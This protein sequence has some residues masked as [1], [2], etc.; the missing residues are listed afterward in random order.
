[1]TP[2]LEGNCR[3]QGPLDESDSEFE[4]NMVCNAGEQSLEVNLPEHTECSISTNA[5]KRC[6]NKEQDGKIEV[7]N[8]GDAL[9]SEKEAT[10][11]E[12]LSELTTSK[13]ATKDFV[14]REEM[15]GSK[16]TRMSSNIRR[17]KGN[18]SRKAGIASRLSDYGQKG[19]IQAISTIEQI[20]K[21][22]EAPDAFQ[23]N[24]KEKILSLGKQSEETCDKSRKAGIVSSHSDNKQKAEIQAT[25]V[26][27][28]SEN[29][30]E[31]PDASQSNE[32]E[33]ILSLGK[34]PEET[35]DK[36]R[37]EGITSSHSDYGQNA[38]IEATGMIE[39]SEKSLE[40]LGASQSY[41]GNIVHLGK[42]SEETC[43]KSRKVG[44]RRSRSDY[45]RKAKTLAT[46]MIEQSEKSL[47]T[48]GVS[49]STDEV[50]IFS[51]GK[52]LEETCD[53]STK[54]GIS[55]S[56]SD[57]GQKAEIQATSTTERSEKSLETPCASQLNDI[58]KILSLGKQ[59]GEI[60]NTSRK[61]SIASNH[62]DYGQKVEIQET[63]SV[64]QSEKSL[65]IPGASHLKDEEKIL[66]HG[67][68]SEES[69]DKCFDKE[70]TDVLQSNEM[71]AIEDIEVHEDERYIRKQEED[72]KELPLT[73]PN[74]ASNINSR[75]SDSVGTTSSKNDL[76]KC[77]MAPIIIL[78][79]INES[80]DSPGMQLTMP[81]CSDSDIHVPGTENSAGM[82][83][84]HVNGVVCNNKHLPEGQV[85]STFSRLE[86]TDE[87]AATQAESLL[88]V[89]VLLKG[90]SES[91]DMINAETTSTLALPRTMNSE[92]AIS[93]LTENSVDVTQKFEIEC[94]AGEFLPQ[95]NNIQIRTPASSN[96]ETI[97]IYADNSFPEHS[98][99]ANAIE[100]VNLSV[101]CGPLD[102]FS[103]SSPEKKE[104]SN[105]FISDGNISQ[106][107][108]SSFPLSV[109]PGNSSITSASQSVTIAKEIEAHS[110]CQQE[111]DVAFT[112]VCTES[113][114]TKNTI[115][116]VEEAKDT[117][118]VA[119]RSPEH[120]QSITTMEE[121]E[122]HSICQQEEDFS[123][124]SVCVESST[125]KN[126]IVVVE[127]AKDKLPVA[128]RSPEHLQNDCLK[129]NELNQ[130]FKFGEASKR[131]GLSELSSSSGVSVPC[132]ETV[133]SPGPLS[134]EDDV[135]TCD[136]CGNTGYEGML[137]VCSLCND[138]AEHTYCM[139]TMLDEVPCGD[140]L[141]EGCKL[142]QN[143]NVKMVETPPS[144]TIISKPTCLNTRKQ[145]SYGT[146]RS[147]LSAKLDK[148]K[149]VPERKRALKGI[150]SSLLSTKRQ[151]DTFE[152]GPATKKLSL[153]TSTSNLGS[154]S[155]NPKPTFSRE[156]S[157]KAPDIGKV[158]TSIAVSSTVNLPN[159]SVNDSGKSSTVY[160]VSSPRL[161]ANV[162]MSKNRLSSVSGR[163]NDFSI[164]TGTSKAGRNA[165]THTVKMSIDPSPP[166]RLNSFHKLSSGPKVV[167][168]SNHTS[169]LAKADRE[170]TSSSQQVGGI[171]KPLKCN[172]NTDSSTVLESRTASDVHNFETKEI[173][174]V[175]VTKDGPGFLRKKV[176]S[177]SSSIG[178]VSKPAGAVNL[179]KL[180]M[181]DRH[182]KP[183]TFPMKDSPKS[184]LVSSEAKRPVTPTQ[185]AANS[186]KDH[187]SLTFAEAGSSSLRVSNLIA[188]AARSLRDMP[189]TVS[190]KLS[191]LEETA[192]L[193]SF[194]N[195]GNDQNSEQRLQQSNS[196][197]DQAQQPGSGSPRQVSS[198]KEASYANQKSN[199]IESF[200]GTT[201]PSQEFDIKTRESCQVSTS[202]RDFGRTS[203]LRESSLINPTCTSS[204][205]AGE[206]IS[207]TGF[208][209]KK[210][211]GVD[212][213]D[214]QKDSCQKGL[215]DDEA[216]FHPGDSSH[217]TTAITHLTG[218]PAEDTVV[219]I[220]GNSSCSVPAPLDGTGPPGTEF[221]V[222]PCRGFS[223]VE[224]TKAT[225]LPEHN[226]LWQGG[227][228]VQSNKNCTHYF[229]GIQAH[230]STSAALKVLDTA[231]KFSSK[232]RL[233][234]VPRNSSWPLQF[235]HC[236]PSDKNIA[237]YFFAKD[238]ESYERPYRKLLD[239]MLKNDLAL[240][241]NF[242]GVELLVF[243]SNQLA[244]KSQRW[245]RLLFL[246]G[247]FREKKS[248]CVESSTC[249]S[250]NI[251]GESAKGDT[252]GSS[253]LNIND[254]TVV[255]HSSSVLGFSAFEEMDT[256][257][258]GDRESNPSE[259]TLRLTGDQ[260]LPSVSSQGEGQNGNYS[261]PNVPNSLLVEDKKVY[262]S[263][264]IDKKAAE[265][266]SV[267]KH[268]VGS[269]FESNEH[270]SSKSLQSNRLNCPDL[271][272]GFET[273]TTHKLYNG[274]DANFFE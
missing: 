139:E 187:N 2:I 236:H 127:E 186:S 245:N 120:R 228:Y 106:E 70:P 214:S 123:F 118:P 63:S 234:E 126:T 195:R 60:Y 260:I 71:P 166:L 238:H 16:K 178:T 101:D 110:I 76:D 251:Q 142:K 47:E 108:V 8:S 243:P 241:G 24:D 14:K 264:K 253:N 91:P 112:S 122:A 72:D 262:R 31:T 162:Q 205:A 84:I 153:G 257:G 28:E 266:S 134:G 136:I 61:A 179:E 165:P 45:G 96:V 167:K 92:K 121:I 98:L 105:R 67:K 54:A 10:G 271:S 183:V 75:N 160:G 131:V 225:S 208:Y 23:S 57:Y 53:K 274:R 220:K 197:Q 81:F 210:K 78:D 259:G 15:P 270:P 117:L 211:S 133:K 51:V 230:A 95:N 272:V 235:H 191:T 217:I 206:K 204:K 216:S 135:K 115:I 66:S 193:H 46:I 6:R 65:E 83:Q 269:S 114:T 172:M 212:D 94:N 247:V 196:Q 239:H 240:R 249:T 64:E 268:S 199:S 219:A 40:T 43:N 17:T 68:Q 261:D 93:V 155:S 52:Q 11:K 169:W 55:S 25:G 248:S 4:T 146:A 255:N 29:T 221:R 129:R 202:C 223:P 58:E 209:E 201:D 39:Q 189:D 254:S 157:F 184:G 69:R 3:I 80:K 258:D 161:P 148:K 5:A 12:S 147:R 88:T 158:K 170:N 175:K 182:A 163:M 226:F 181:D 100:P 213:T 35:F 73:K 185:V 171:T 77:N 56:H 107:V 128:A 222:V 104:S 256:D 150:P 194:K 224:P 242:D 265:H 156:N 86:N 74:G 252:L 33:K 138:G 34:Q 113:S 19:E 21:S 27:E 44:I 130:D 103:S 173:R 168:D 30:L 215:L 143:V 85:I 36:A 13:S 152:V 177:K 20:E 232:L 116:V 37:K 32:E 250:E 41:D 174:T 188:S 42:Q 50:K 145:N 190:G 49:Q 1:I 273:S 22:L 227:F 102:H 87:L 203:G 263:L 140:W 18:K 198:N 229:E 90:T 26:I 192:P 144:L 159:S 82:P 218:F 62:L 59:S 119:A 237:L 79:E 200:K 111:E 137:A 154:L 99:S 97:T 180:A 233:D 9:L 231:K 207:H 109:T 125:T 164:V 176:M 149:L 89:N 124:T 38:E 141:C 7:H 48:P 151:A 132:D 267:K 246:W 244:E